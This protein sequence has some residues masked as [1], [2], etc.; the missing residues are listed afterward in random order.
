MSNFFLL[1][2]DLKN[3][4]RIKKL[5][6]N[7]EVDYLGQA[8]SSALNSYQLEFPEKCESI[9]PEPSP[10]PEPESEP[11]PSPEPSPE[12]EPSTEPEPEP[13]PNLP[14]YTIVQDTGS[15]ILQNESGAYLWKFDLPP[16]S[17]EPRLS[18]DGFT[19]ENSS[20]AS[21]DA[22]LEYVNYLSSETITIHPGGSSNFVPEQGVT[23]P[24][25]GLIARLNLDGYIYYS[26]VAFEPWY[27]PF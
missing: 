27:N 14:V 19:I 11:E 10:E 8:V 18:K 9:S 23:P 13:L 2:P 6:I 24:K 21:Y 1:T 22:Y 15:G 5:E 17:S 7:S 3:A 16:P 4:D 20:L 26:E 12:P 25:E